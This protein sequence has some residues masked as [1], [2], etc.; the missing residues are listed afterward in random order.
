M[1]ASTFG[2]EFGVGDKIEKKKRKTLLDCF[3]SRSE[4]EYLIHRGYQSIFAAPG[5]DV[6]NGVESTGEGQGCVGKIPVF[7]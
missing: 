4:R 6:S 2:W 1:L 5:T 3:L 7:F